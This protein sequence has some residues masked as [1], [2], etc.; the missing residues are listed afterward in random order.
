[1]RQRNEEN[2]CFKGAII[3]VSKKN[4]KSFVCSFCC[5][6]LPLH[7]EALSFLFFENLRILIY[8]RTQVFIFAKIVFT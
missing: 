2:R 5:S 3:L 8:C 4:L 6:P 7:L 1:M